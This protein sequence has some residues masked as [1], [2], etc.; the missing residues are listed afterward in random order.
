M[1][2]DTWN[3]I[4]Y[5]LH[6]LLADRADIFAECGAEH[7]DLLAMGSAAEDFLHVFAHICGGEGGR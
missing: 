6:E 3:A 1:L 7:H 4:V 2:R 5:I